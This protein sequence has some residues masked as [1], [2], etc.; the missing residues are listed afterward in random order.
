MAKKI[1]KNSP[2]DFLATVISGVL[3]GLLGYIVAGQFV[4]VAYYPFLWV[5]LSFI[6]SYMNIYKKD[7]IYFGQ[8]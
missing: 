7:L 5:G 6:V 3:L 1:Y 8:S 2:D 4:S